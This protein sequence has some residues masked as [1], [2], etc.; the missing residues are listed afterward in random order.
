M[1][2]TQETWFDPWVGKIP[3]R[4][5]GSPPCSCLENPTD[6]GAW[7]ASVCGVPQSQTR[8]SDQIREQSHFT[9]EDDEISGT[10]RLTQG[11]EPRLKSTLWKEDREATP[12]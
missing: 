5:N 9:D 3:G 7:W 6:R 8:L 4:G 11:S 10:G 2:E 12:V 1:Q